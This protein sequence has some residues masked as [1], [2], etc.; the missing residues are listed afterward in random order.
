MAV[1]LFFNEEYFDELFTCSID[2]AK[3]FN[4]LVYGV[5]Q[6]IRDGAKDYL[7]TSIHFRSVQLAVNYS[8]N[9][10]MNDKR[11]DQ[12]NK[13]LVDRDLRLYFARKVDKSPYYEEYPKDDK[14]LDCEIYVDIKG[15]EKGSVFLTRCYL[16][17]GITVSPKISVF[18]SSTLNAKLYQATEADSE[19]IHIKCIVDEVTVLEHQQLIQSSAGYEI[20]RSSDIWELR[21]TLFPN[22]I[23]CGHIEEQL[24]KLE[25]WS[26]VLTRLNE[27]Q[28]YAMSWHEGPFNKDKIPS[29][30]SGESQTVRNNRTARESRTFMCPDDQERIFYWHLRAT[31]GCLRIHFYPDEDSLDKNIFIGHIGE[32]LYYP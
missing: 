27:L 11:I 15:D 3:A 14:Y 4:K 16:D 28:V 18:N 29:K 10:W 13:P 20:T 7:V 24:N 9:D 22:L 21:A 19:E 30:V 26:V 5:M 2:A 31:P 12:D 8:I 1:S 25:H 32:K 17:S 23:F 6:A